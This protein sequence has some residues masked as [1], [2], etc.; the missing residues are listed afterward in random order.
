MVHLHR[1]LAAGLDVQKLDLK[2][3]ADAERL[4]VAPRP[5][6]SEVLLLLLAVRLLQ[7]LHDLRDVLRAALVGDEQRVGRVDDDEVLD[8]DGRDERPL[9]MDVAVGRIF[10]HG[11]ALDEVALVV[12]GRDVPQRRPGA[13]VVPADV[14]RQHR[15]GAASSPSPR[16][17]SEMLG[18]AAKPVLSR[19]RKPRSSVA[20]A[21][22]ARA[23][24]RISGS[25]R[26]ISSRYVLAFSTK[27]PLF[28][29]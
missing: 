27:M 16:S 28:Q 5:V 29:K 24:S 1:Q 22:A 3:R 7:A 4:E 15:G 26:S 9:G 13:D 8:A 19:R 6:V 20:P 2:A 17:R 12:S 25:S 18:D 10:E 21:S 23:A 14:E 11:V